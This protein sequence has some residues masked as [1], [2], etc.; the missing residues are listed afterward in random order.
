MKGENTALEAGEAPSGGGRSIRRRLPCVLVVLDPS[1]P[2]AVH[3][4]PAATADLKQQ[5]QPVEHAPARRGPL[6]PI[7]NDGENDEK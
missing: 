6:L 4:A 5:Q 7:I 3:P 2:H 1:G